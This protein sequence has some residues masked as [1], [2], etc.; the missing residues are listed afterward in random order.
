[1]AKGVFGREK[2]PTEHLSDSVSLFG[3]DFAATIVPEAVETI[4]ALSRA[5][6]VSFI[7]TANA[8]SC[9][10]PCQQPPIP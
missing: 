8:D 3:F 7:V 6:R 4:I 1:V 9:R 2:R 10:R 5:P